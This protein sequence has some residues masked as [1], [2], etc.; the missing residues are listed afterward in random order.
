LARDGATAAFF[1]VL[2]CELFE[3]LVGGDHDQQPPQAVAVIKLREPPSVHCLKEAVESVLHHVFFIGAAGA[4]V[5]HLL[6][7][8]LDQLAI[9]PL[10]QRLGGGRIALFECRD[11]MR[12]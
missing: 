10:P 8:Q 12:D 5:A 7:G 1:T 3:G 4:S 9:V 2:V 6:A 11:P